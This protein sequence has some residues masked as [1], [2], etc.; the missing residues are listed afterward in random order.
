MNLARVWLLCALLTAGH[1]AAQDRVRLV[2]QPDIAP[3]AAAFPRL[4]PTEAQAARINQALAAADARAKAAADE[5]RSQSEGSSADPKT[6]EWTRQIAVAMQGPRY[7]AFFASD[8]S[9]CGGMHPN[10][11]GIALT[12]DLRTG[13]PPNWATLLPRRLVDKTTVEL[14][15]DA[16]PLGM[17]TSPALKAI[18]LEASRKAAQAVAP[19]CPHALRERA[20]PF[21]LWP[22]ARHG[23]AIQ[24]SHL[25]Q[26]EAACGVPALIGMDTLRR[27]GVQPALLDALAAGHRAR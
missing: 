8:Y 25:A 12:Y 11:T 19:Q 2:A 24:P 5:C 6:L 14:A 16:T 26:A 3:K 4:A 20:G 21:M 23:I 22:D 15:M 27:E 17:V 1:A 18:Y 7:L 10:A 13:Q 9:Y